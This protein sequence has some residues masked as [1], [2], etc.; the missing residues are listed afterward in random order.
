MRVRP[1]VVFARDL[2]GG[3]DHQKTGWHFTVQRN[4]FTDAVWSPIVVSSTQKASASDGAAA[5]FSAMTVKVPLPT[6]PARYRVQVKMFWYRNGATEGTATHT[7]DFYFRQIPDRLADGRAGR[8]L[9]GW[10]R[11]LAVLIS[12][13]IYLRGETPATTGEPPAGTSR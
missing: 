6:Q 3:V 13:R 11:Q 2:T 7:V 5:Q 1:P 4:T 8:G 10:D 12:G 9:P